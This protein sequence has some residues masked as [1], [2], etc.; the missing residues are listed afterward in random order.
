M[1][2][3]YPPPPRNSEPTCSLM[4]AFVV[5]GLSIGVVAAACSYEED[6]T[7]HEKALDVIS[8]DYKQ[9]AINARVYLREHGNYAGFT[10]TSRIYPGAD[11]NI[12]HLM[13][14]SL[15]VVTTYPEVEGIVCYL[16][17]GQTAKDSL[18]I[19]ADSIQRS[20]AQ[21]VCQ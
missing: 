17:L 16:A 21:S 6:F 18:P 19:P 4:E 5:I 15:L 7:P 3:S 13:P 11:H 1:M 10:F 8:A 12:K 9:I 20:F 2:M 14:R